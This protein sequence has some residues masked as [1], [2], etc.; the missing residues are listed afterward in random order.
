[1]ELSQFGIF[2]FGNISSSEK[3]PCHHSICRFWTNEQGEKIFNPFLICLNLL[4]SKSSS[5]DPVEV[6]YTFGIY[7]RAKEQ[8]DKCPE[9]VTSVVLDRSD[10][11]QSVGVENVTL[12]DENCNE[13]GDI[14]LKLR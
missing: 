13:D 5:G 14:L 2:Q 6:T 9:G 4:E 3:H 11:I 7:N 1:M 8:Y 10:Q 12:K